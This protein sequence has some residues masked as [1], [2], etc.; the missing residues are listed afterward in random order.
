MA[1]GEWKRLQAA[2]LGKENQDLYAKYVK[3]QQEANNVGRALKEAV[4]AEWNHRHP[5]G[6][7]GKFYTF[8]A[9]NGILYF[10]ELKGK[11][12]T[13]AGLN[14]EAGEDIFGAPPP[15]TPAVQDSHKGRR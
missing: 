4:R 13:A 14:L 8:N 5:Q 12:R 11:A 9:A 6:M 3:A 15:E 2:N 7:N 10:Q 1:S